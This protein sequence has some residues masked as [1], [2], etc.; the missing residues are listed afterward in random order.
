MLSWREKKLGEEFVAFDLGRERGA[1]NG[2]FVTGCDA[3]YEMQGPSFVSE[4]PS[5]VEFTNVNGGRVDCTVRGN[6]AP[7]VDW[8][9]ADGGSITSIPGIR[10]VLGNGTIHFPGF[11][12][13]VFR[14][15]VH[16]AI[17]KC[18][19]VN[20]V[21]GIVSRDV[22]VR[23]GTRNFSLVIRITPILS[24]FRASNPLS[25]VEER[26]KGGGGDRSMEKF[27]RDYSREIAPIRRYICRVFLLVC[28]VSSWFLPGNGAYTSETSFGECK[29]LMAVEGGENIRHAFNEI[30]DDV[31]H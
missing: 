12:A 8:L 23:A 3:S 14:Q 9:A 17:Y 4:P 26:G 5:R 15:D 7:T 22:T 2:C 20:S 28:A 13:E 30:L 25:S 27:G 31:L 1:C 11:E 19:A 16:W 6:P 18:S 21:G 24:S 29:S 10:H